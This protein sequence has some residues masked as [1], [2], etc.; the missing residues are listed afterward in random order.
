VICTEVGK[1][2][3]HQT[4]IY[5]LNPGLTTTARVCFAM[6]ENIESTIKDFNG[7]LDIMIESEAS[8]LFITADLP[9]SIKVHGNIEPI[10]GKPLTPQQSHQLAYNLM[11][12]SQRHEFDRNLECN[13]AIAPSENARF[14]VNIFRQKNQMGIVLRRI[15]T[16]IPT[17]EDLR[18]PSTLTQLSLDKRGLVIIV[19]GTGSGKSSTLAAM[20]GYRNQHGNG[21]IITVE[22]P[23]EFIH[24]HSGCIITQRE[25]GV[26]TINFEAALQNTLRQAPDVILIGEIR[27][28]ETMEHALAFAETGHLVLTT[29]H[30][31]NANQ[32]MER[33]LNFF[34]KDRRD[35]VLLD[36]SLNLNAIVAQQL[37]PRPDH[38]SR[39]VAVEVLLNT[40][41][42]AQL[43][44]KG[45][46][47]S[48]KE[49]MAKS[50]NLG[51]ITFDQALYE[52]YKAGEITY[53][54]AIHHADSANEL[55]LMVK[56]DQDVVFP[57]DEVSGSFSLV[58]DVEDTRTFTIA[59][60]EDA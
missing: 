44:K 34:P 24:E 22:D 45:D 19:G 2:F 7:L 4:W 55:R 43:V 13:F 16:I 9:P 29:L 35:S 59:R 56:L 37:I 15:N 50:N 33:I 51:M 30:A 10:S 18:I 48:L 42:V 17:A 39:V 12:R 5:P 21:H 41:L 3:P 49:I 47:S 1:G 52:L 20:I 60:M 46:V 23:I 36:L 14:R 32:T 40:P 38:K 26:D 6:F 25:V 58:Q 8:D 31:N 53:E 27:N 28:R 54:D 57:E 11:D